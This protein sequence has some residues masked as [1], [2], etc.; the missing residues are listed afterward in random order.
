M[1][2]PRGLWDQTGVSDGWFDE[3]QQPVG[4]FDADSLDVTSGAVAY[5]LS[6]AAGSYAYTGQ[7]A[8]FT[9]GRNLSGA[10]GA[11]AYT[12]QAATLTYTSGAG[13]VA[14]ALS[15]DAGAYAYTGQNATLTYTSGAPIPFAGGGGG[16]GGR[17]GYRPRFQI[18]YPNVKRGK[19]LDKKI[20]EWIEAIVAGEPEAEEP[21]EVTQVR[22]V[23]APYVR[24]DTIDLAAMQ[25]DAK[26]VRALLKAYEAEAKR[27]A[28]EED[29]ELLMMVL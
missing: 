10:A 3:T 20:G 5:T 18:I 6:G 2:I 23:V 8:S 27:Q 16:G 12:G 17:I 26:Q 21:A 15:G 25:R 13:A 22:K 4:W 1:T 24:E 14:Y 29:D 28:D 9:V 19:T 11:Y 7:T